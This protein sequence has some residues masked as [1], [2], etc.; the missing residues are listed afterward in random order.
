MGGVNAPHS[1]ESVIPGALL[2]AIMDGDVNG[3]WFIAQDYAGLS[4]ASAMKKAKFYYSQ[5][6]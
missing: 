6:G 4:L 2:G 5:E 1:V 3:R